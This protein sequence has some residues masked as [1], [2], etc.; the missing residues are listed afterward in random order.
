MNSQTW[1]VVASDGGNLVLKT[2]GASDGAFEP[3]L[4][5]AARLDRAGVLT[6]LSDAEGNL[7][8]LNDARRGLGC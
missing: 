7:K 6:G 5:A 4:E 3:G 2:V 8:G 1:P